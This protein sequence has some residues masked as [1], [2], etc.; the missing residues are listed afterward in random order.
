MIPTPIRF[1]AGVLHLLDQR[2]LPAQEVWIDCHGAADAGRAIADLVVRGAPAIGITAAYGMA[3][4]GRRAGPDQLETSARELID[5]RPTA[6][7]LA[8]A[9]ERMMQRARGAAGN[10]E[11]L[12]TALT[13]EALAIH[14]E[15]ADSCRAIGRHGLTLLSDAPR[16]LTHCNAG[17]LATG[18]IGTALAPV[19]AAMEAGRNPEVF[20]CEARPV[21]QGSRLT[22][23]ELSRAGVPVTLLVDSAAAFLIRSGEVE[24]IWVGADRIAAN[25]DVANKVGTL[26]LACAASLADVPFYVAA[27]RSTFDSGTPNGAAIPIEH[28]DPAELAARFSEPVS[29]RETRFWTPA[30]DITPVDLVTAYVSEEGITPGGRSKSA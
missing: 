21:M 17:A 4:E 27:P 6:I 10:G 9:V 28:R 11:D 12:A 30:F 2:L 1:D 20:A 29:A 24:S 3:L 19:Y 5:A 8:W 18:G 15:D 13:E 26:N 23:W 14:R 16:V 7:N 22:T 25:G